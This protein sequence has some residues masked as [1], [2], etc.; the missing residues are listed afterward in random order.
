MQR[1]QW[2]C[3]MLMS[4]RITNLDMASKFIQSSISVDAWSVA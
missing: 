4:E 3:G 2:Q 1:L